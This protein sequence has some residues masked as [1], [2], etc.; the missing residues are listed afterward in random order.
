MLA[1]VAGVAL[2]LELA[3][4]TLTVSVVLDIL[5]RV[6]RGF[7]GTTALI[8]AGVMV[9]V[10]LLAI[11]LPPAP[12]LLNGAISSGAL[13]SFVHWCLVF[14]GVL[15]VDA[16]F[17]VVGT[18]RAR[19]V[20]GAA[21]IACGGTALGKLVVAFGPALGGS[22]AVA[23]AVVPSTLLAGS[24][25]AGMLLGHWY[26]VSPALSFR[27]LRQASYTVLTAVAVQATAVAVVV[28]TAAP[29]ARDA[30]VSTTYAL[31]FWGL[32]VG[33]GIVFTTAVTLLTLYFARIRANQPATAM[34]YALIISVVMGIVPGHLLF[35]LTGA[36][37]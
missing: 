25:L 8:C 27:P 30:L 17:S 1:P 19:R 14:G 34:L 6:G 18:E 10:L 29:P 32:V 16:L 23:V 21:T 26:L 12:H 35:F 7:A 4:G 24:A 37:V 33:A 20:V 36:P 15:L 9:V 3:V 22:F 5:G 31:P 11:A 13:S 2:L 28:V